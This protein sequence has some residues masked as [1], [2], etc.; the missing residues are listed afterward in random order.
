MPS[1][2]L[3]RR[4]EGLFAKVSDKGFLSNR[5]IGN[6]IGFYIF[7]Y[8]PQDEPVVGSYIPKLAERLA[9]AGVKVTQFNLYELILDLLK[10]RDL[11]KQ[12]FELEARK[13]SAGLEKALKK[14]IRPERINELITARLTEPHDLV[15]ITGVGAAYPLIRSHT[16]LN[17]LHSVVDKVPVVMF[18]P[19]SYT[20]QELKLFDAL[21]DDNYYRAFPLLQEAVS[22]A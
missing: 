11:L 13:G 8:A 5:G 15:F 3:G 4:L 7:A 6:E 16:V 1:E 18:F 10:E 14:I 17:N 12:T 20:G 9:G 2:I 19:G 22:Q 21:K